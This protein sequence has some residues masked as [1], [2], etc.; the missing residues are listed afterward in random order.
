MQ[1]TQSQDEGGA[2][3]TIGSILDTKTEAAASTAFGFPLP[4]N[5]RIITHWSGILEARV[6]IQLYHFLYDF[7]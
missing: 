5:P 4:L 2:T 3:Q 6:L 1:K 7:W